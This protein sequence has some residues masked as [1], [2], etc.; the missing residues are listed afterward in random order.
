MRWWPRS[1]RA[2]RCVGRAIVFPPR[3]GQHNQWYQCDQCQTALRTLDGI[4]HQCPRCNVIYTGE[5]YDDVIFAR[6]HNEILRN[7]ESAAWAYAITRNQKYAQYA[8][9]VLLGYAERYSSYPYHDANRKTGKSASASGGHLFEQTL[10]EAACLAGEIGPAYD[11][12]YDSGVFCPTDH[13]KIR[14]GLLL[15]M[16]GN[17]DKHKAGKGNWQTWHNAAMFA[18]APLVGNVE[19]ARKAIGQPGNGFVHQM[20]VSVSK[21]GLWYENSWGYHFYTL[22][23]MVHIVE[24]ARRLGINL[25]SHSALK[26]MF[27]LPVAYAMPDGSLPRFGDDVHTTIGQASEYLEYAWHAYHDPAML[28]YLPS[29]PTWDSVMLGRKA[30]ERP[31]ARAPET[32]IFQASG[33]AVLRGGGPAGLAA[34]MA[35]GPYGGFHGHFDKLSFVFFG[36]GQELGVDPGRAKSQAYRLP[37]HRD[38]YKATLSHNAV[39]VDGRSQN[40]AAG[41]LEFFAAND[42]YAVAVAR[43]GEAYPGT[44][45]R[46]LLCLMPGS[47]VVF[48]EMKSAGERRFDWVY[49]NRGTEVVCERSPE[50]RQVRGEVPR[51][52]VRRSRQGG[53]DCGACSGDVRG[54]KGRDMVDWERLRGNRS[55]DRRRRRRGDHRPGAHNNAHPPRPGGSVRRGV[56]AVAQGPASTDQGGSRRAGRRGNGGDDPPRQKR[57]EARVGRGRQGQVAKRREDRGLEASGAVTELV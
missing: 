50:G 45:H 36:F 31:R 4:H 3:G 47:L 19:W 15:P 23:A 38:W 37:V 29:R 25:W 20:E 41:R 28:P 44:T 49:H 16:L 8:R 24:G 1:F 57:G 35:F 30:G 21:D 5:P 6:R 22:R 46:R 27:T 17:I 56:G 34:V 11:L 33:H 48:D 26:K 51:P 40:P 32:C 10:N 12:V 52:R 7:L 2:A 55:K 9:A 18:A 42:E 43:C 54:T 13:D 53:N 14:T 39:L